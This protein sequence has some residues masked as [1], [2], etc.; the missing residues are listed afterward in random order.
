MDSNSYMGQIAGGITTS[1]FSFTLVV[2][3]DLS[4]VLKYGQISK[5]LVFYFEN[6]MCT[7]MNIYICYEYDLAA[8]SLAVKD[9]GLIDNQK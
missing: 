7:S 3:I 1:L 9:L 6:Q 8:N 2:F 4:I 5:T